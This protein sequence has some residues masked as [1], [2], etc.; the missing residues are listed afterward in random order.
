MKLADAIVNDIL[1]EMYLYDELAKTLDT[2][3]PPLY[4]NLFSDLKM[5]VNK[6]L[7]ESGAVILQPVTMF[8]I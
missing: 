1:D 3:R 4:G 5:R 8:D 7:H 2:L 6:R